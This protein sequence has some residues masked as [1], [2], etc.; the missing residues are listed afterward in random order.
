MI[1]V[2]DILSMVYSE[3]KK[4]MLTSE[5]CVVEVVGSLERPPPKPSLCLC[6]FFFFFSCLSGLEPSCNN[7]ETNI[8]VIII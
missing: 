2:G 7:V 5:A 3:V 8:E 4:V 6:F 1:Q